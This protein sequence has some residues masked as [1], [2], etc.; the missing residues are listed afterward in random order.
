MSEQS[1]PPTEKICPV[2]GQDVPAGEYCGACGA[3]LRTG[4]AA[5]SHAFAA[6]PEEHLFHPG[7][8]STLFPHLPRRHAAPFRL[9]LLAGVVVL[10]VFGLLGLTGAGIATAA[11]VVPLLYLIYLYEV[12]VYEDEPLIVIG[13]TFILGLL[14]GI[15]WALYTGHFS[16]DTLV[17]NATFGAPLWKILAYGPGLSLAAQALMLVGC[18][19]IYARKRYD[20]VLDGFV[21]GAAGALGFTLAV[22]VVE[23]WP[24]LS[25]G[26][27]SGAPTVDNTLAILGRGLLLPFIAA[28]ATGLIGGALWLRRGKT[29]PAT[30]FGWTTRIDSVVLLVI[31]LWV[32]LG[33]VNV[34]VTSIVVTVCIYAAVAMV[35]LL[36][37]RV[38]LHHML[39]AEAV[40]TRVGP[41]TVCFHCH[42][43]VPRMA[44]CPHCGVAT[45]ATPKTG[46]GRLE[47][48]YR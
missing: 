38:A 4:S 12:D 9:A 43:S 41:D 48:A 28:T 29:R 34:L 3:Y 33:L 23:L 46:H 40:D 11:L 27:R 26:V 5:R 16:T 30:A 31:C 15:P 47:R 32:G 7:I 19:V 22:T 13:S 21:F 18:L 17:A 6:H 14:I 24:Q 2:C 8:I 37:A 39:L 1:L 25:Q 44:F 10:V 45:R 42:H 36:A 20:E 35:L